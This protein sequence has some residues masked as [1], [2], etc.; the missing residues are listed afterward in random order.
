MSKD[1]MSR[2]L[3][4]MIQEKTKPKP[5]QEKE[6]LY[7][8]WKWDGDGSEGYAKEITHTEDRQP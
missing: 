1:T 3:T 4:E 2:E 6:R 7:L 5:K 8:H